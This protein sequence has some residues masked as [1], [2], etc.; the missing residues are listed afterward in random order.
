MKI[1]SREYL[2]KE[3][4]SEENKKWK[5]V[6]AQPLVSYEAEYDIGIKLLLAV[7]IGN[8]IFSFFGLF[9]DFGTMLYQVFTLFKVIGERFHAGFFSSYYSWHPVL[10]QVVFVIIELFL[11]AMV[12]AKSKAGRM[13]YIVVSVLAI[14]CELGIVFGWFSSESNFA[15]GR[16]W[17]MLGEEF[18]GL[19][20]LVVL[21]AQIIFHATALIVLFKSKKVKLYLNYRVL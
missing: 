20:S 5:E 15:G 12:L 18:S 9:F 17:A 8:V 1:F 2:E 19:W 6:S 21:L 7:L 16:I 3:Y 13:I 10:T 11:S 14:L 4:A